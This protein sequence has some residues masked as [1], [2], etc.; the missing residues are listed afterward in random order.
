MKTP[1]DTL[2]EKRYGLLIAILIVLI[3]YLGGGYFMYSQFFAA[4]PTSAGTFGDMFGGI[5]SF[6]SAVTVILVLYASKLQKQEL[7]A[8]RK[9]FVEQ[10][11][12]TKLQ[13]FETTFFNM[14]GLY[15]KIK[16]D[17]KL[18][19]GEEFVSNPNLFLSGHAQSIFGHGDQALEAALEFWNTQFKIQ[20]RYSYINNVAFENI[21][22]SGE[23]REMEMPTYFNH[24]TNVFTFI[25]DSELK[26][27]KIIFYTKTFTALLTS[28]EA[29]L[30][31]YY[32]G[33]QKGIDV[34][35][36][37]FIRQHYFATIDRSK[38]GHPTYWDMHF[39]L[40]T[41]RSK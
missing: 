31:F 21:F 6:F 22:K 36:K 13:R 18:V 2:L 25:K 23:N 24:V 19:V 5:T 14:L 7:D 8:T 10:N 38:L 33:L 34:E 28:T 39:P 15:Q 3:I 11:E 17:L 29:T 12:T 16:A 4:N 1:F 41:N 40:D 30:I 32:I 9:E 26:A 20:D 35:L 37:V 27:E